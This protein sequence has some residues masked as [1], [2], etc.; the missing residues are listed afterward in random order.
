MFNWGFIQ[1]GKKIDFE[2]V[3]INTIVQQWK[4]HKGHIHKLHLAHI[5]S[6]IANK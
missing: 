2:T 3:F 1:L 5:K 6:F 4:K